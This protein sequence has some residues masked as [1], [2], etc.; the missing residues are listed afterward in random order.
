M[1]YIIMEDMYENMSSG[2]V[3]KYLVKT[4]DKVKKGQPVAE[5]IAEGYWTLTAP[6]TGYIG[7]FF[8]DEEEYVEVGTPLIEIEIKEDE[9]EKN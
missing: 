6:E 4:G 3:E 5:I 9:E 1:D 7:E 8:V 2:K